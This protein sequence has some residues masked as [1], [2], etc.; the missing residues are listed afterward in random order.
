MK[1]R[2][3]YYYGQIVQGLEYNPRL[4]LYLLIFAVVLVYAYQFASQ[5]STQWMVAGFASLGILAGLAIMVWPFQAVMLYLGLAI[6]YHAF[7]R[8]E[9]MVG[10]GS[11]LVYP[12]DV[13]VG[14][15]L[16]VEF[17]RGCMRQTHL[18][19]ATD[20]WMVALYAWALCCVT[21]GVFEYGYSSIGESRE[22]LH[23]ISYFIAIHYVTRVE[24]TDSVLRWLKWIAV[25]SSVYQVYNFVFVNQFS[26]R[27]AGGGPLAV[28]ASLNVVVLAVLLG[29]DHIKKTLSM[30]PIAAAVGC[31]AL[32]GGL[33]FL[34]EY[35]GEAAVIWLKIPI[36]ACLV[37]A[38][39]IILQYRVPAAIALM[40]QFALVLYSSQRA[41]TMCVLAT[42]PFLLWIGRRHFLKAVLLIGMS[43]TLFIAWL[44]FMNPTF[45]GQLIPYMQKQFTGIVAPHEDPTAAWRLYGWRWEMER[46][47]SN[48]F[49]VLIGQGFGGYYDWYFNLT[50][51]VIRT[52]PHNV[53]VQIW[54][55]QGF[56][57]LGL[58]GAV[59]LSFFRS[60]F[61]FLIRSQNELHRSIMMILMLEV[62]GNLVNQIG[63]QFVASLWVVLALGTVLPRLWLAEQ[64]GSSAIRTGATSPL[65][66]R[67]QARTL[68]RSPTLISQRLHS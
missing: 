64:P 48:P 63:G 47:F 10:M 45:G 6:W 38:T 54:S 19:T 11:A 23:C 25:I 27:F 28:F 50:D 26:P 55:K 1:T 4:F 57:G 34:I 65:H 24:Q 9:T 39:A 51:A 17:F 8:G 68:P 32:A 30:L 62:F 2:R 53:Y 60:G 49:W 12:G 59:L 67:E 21:R 42:I 44:A 13:F 66:H 61:R 22:F 36:G 20:R 15:F 5:V 37:W 43:V 35:T 31:I 40:L 29:R 52:A 56:V 14:A 3:S 18:Y 33:Y 7:L 46:I 41:S 58:F 16:V